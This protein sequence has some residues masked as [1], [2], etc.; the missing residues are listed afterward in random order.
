VTRDVLLQV[1]VQRVFVTLCNSTL[2]AIIVP[3]VLE[4]MHALQWHRVI[5]SDLWFRAHNFHGLDVLRVSVSD[6]VFLHGALDTL[7]GMDQVVEDGHLPLPTLALRETLGVD[8]THLLQN[9]RLA[10]LAS[11]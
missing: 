2:N 4:S 9:C 7:E 6:V 11:T 3:Q 1:V 10:A 8:Q 5:G